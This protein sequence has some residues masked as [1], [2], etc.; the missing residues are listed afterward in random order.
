MTTAQQYL[1]NKLIQKFNIDVV[2][3]VEYC[4]KARCLG[5]ARLYGVAGVPCR[6]EIAVVDPKDMNTLAHELIQRIRSLLRIQR[7][8]RLGAAS[9]LGT[10]R[11]EIVNC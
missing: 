10:T 11:V 5:E 2:V 1:I 9:T 4:R 7:I 3:D 8:K 6:L